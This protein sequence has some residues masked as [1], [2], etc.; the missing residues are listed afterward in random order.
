MNTLKTGFLLVVLT[1][2]LVSVGWLIGQTVGLVIAFGLALAMNGF[3]YWFS[4]KL[5][6]R[7]AGAQ[8]ISPLEGKEL[9]EYADRLAQLYNVPKPR[10]YLSQDPAPNAFATGRNP[11]HAAICVNVGLLRLLD[12]RQ[13][14][15]VLAHEFAHVGNRD[16]LISSVA[17]VLAGAITFI[18]NIAS[19]GLWFGG[20]D[21]DEGNPLGFIGVL[22]AIILAPLAAIVIQLAISRSREL[23]ADRTAAQRTGDPLAL[24]SALQALQ[25]GNEAVPSP[26]AQPAYAHLYITNPLQGGGLRGLF[27]TH[28]PIE[29]RVRRLQEMAQRGPALA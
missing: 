29:E 12:R 4:D 24:A 23:Q 21:D 2:V 16:I 17:A 13:V 6:L 9:H 10:V 26:S 27:S 5:A 14:F 15:A 8:E 22:A 7:A 28:P 1:V 3:A 11:K 20:G 18:A 25:R 19:F